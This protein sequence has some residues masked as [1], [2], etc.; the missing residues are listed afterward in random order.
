MKK[1]KTKSI[2]SL[3]MGEIRKSMVKQGFFDGR[4]EA[5]SIPDKKKE[6]SRRACRKR[7]RL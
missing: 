2:R 6:A 5:R 1:K 4:F 3:M 7:I